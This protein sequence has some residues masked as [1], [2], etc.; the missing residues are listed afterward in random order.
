MDNT[1][2]ANNKKKNHYAEGKERERESIKTIYHELAPVPSM[3]RMKKKKNK[4]TNV[5]HTPG[6]MHM[7]WEV[8]KYTIDK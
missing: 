5:I 3:T 2:V 7:K 8:A 6:S 1:Y 4:Q